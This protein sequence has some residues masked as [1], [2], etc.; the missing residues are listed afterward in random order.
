[1][2]SFPTFFSSD[3][4]SSKRIL[5]LRYTVHRAMFY[6]PWKIWNENAFQWSYQ[7]PPATLLKPE[8]CT[9]LQRNILVLP[10]IIPYTG[11]HPPVRWACCSIVDERFRSI[12]ARLYL[13]VRWATPGVACIWIL[14]IFY[15]QYRFSYRPAGGD[16]IG[17]AYFGQLLRKGDCT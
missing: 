6:C 5:P 15:C 3:K 4:L 17:C 10:E 13:R 11:F 8:V 2:K 9:T 12:V 16:Q 14:S 7:Q 1:M